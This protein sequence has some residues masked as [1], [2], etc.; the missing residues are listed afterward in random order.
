MTIPPSVARRAYQAA[1]DGSNSSF[2]Y[3]RRFVSTV[4]GPDEFVVVTCRMT[5][6]D[7]GSPFSLTKV[8]LAFSRT[9]KPILFIS[10]GEKLPSITAEISYT[11]AG[12][13]KGRWE[14]VQPGEEPPQPNDLLTEATLPIE[15]RGTQRRYT[16]LSRFNVFLPPEGKYILP[17]PDPKTLPMKVAGEHQILL[18]I[19][20][21]DNDVSI[22]NLAAVGAGPGVVNSG[23]VAG[24][25]LPVLRYFVGPASDDNAV[26][27]LLAPE[28]N[29]V[30]AAGQTIEFTWLDVTKATVYRLELVDATGKSVL[31]ALLPAGKGF[32][33]APPWL[34]QQ[35]KVDELRWRVIALDESGQQVGVSDWRRLQF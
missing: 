13:L 28:E 25:S 12:R 8:D 14:V 23:A 24:F 19:E 18:R 6:G 11:G 29:Q 34:G 31:S 32:Y 21:S 16:Q 2:F 3:V 35:S 5:G 33:R 10:P 1:V 26:V 30:F 17:G 4:G 22:S 15:Q 20:A 7:A 9:E 27:R